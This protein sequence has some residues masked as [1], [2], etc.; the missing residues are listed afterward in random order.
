MVAPRFPQEVVTWLEKT[1][2][3][4][5]VLP[6]DLIPTREL[7]MRIGVKRVVDRVRREFDKQN[8]PNAPIIARR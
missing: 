7:D 2:L 1:F 6:T 8:D 5:T 3:A 4:E